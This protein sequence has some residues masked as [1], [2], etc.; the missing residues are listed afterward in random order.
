MDLQ[1]SNSLQTYLYYFAAW[2]RVANSIFSVY[3]P[4]PQQRDLSQ[5]LLR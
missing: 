5:H 2:L 1:I 4:N 3:F